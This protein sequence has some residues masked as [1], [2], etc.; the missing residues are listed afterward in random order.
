VFVLSFPSSALSARPTGF[1]PQAAGELT[2]Q[3]DAISDVEVAIAESTN[4]FSIAVEWFDP[5]GALG[6]RDRR[7]R[8]TGDSATLVDGA[9]WVWPIA[10]LPTTAISTDSPRPGAVPLL[11]V[12]VGK[13]QSDRRLLCVG[14]NDSICP[15]IK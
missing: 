2:Q 6:G 7:S 14:D 5:E 11:A 13:T 3:T 12:A 15:D 8:S 1:L 10:A 9:V 4:V